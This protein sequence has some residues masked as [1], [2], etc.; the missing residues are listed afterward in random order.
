MKVTKIIFGAIEQVFD[1]KTQ[2]FVSQQFVEHTEIK[3]QYRSDVS[4]YLYRDE[5]DL[6][7][8][9]TG[10]EANLEIKLNQPTTETTP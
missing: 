10:L 5:I 6:I 7:D 4:G 1:T 3:T 9:E 2:Q 8:K